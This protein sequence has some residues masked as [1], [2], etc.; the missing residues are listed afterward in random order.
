MEISNIR[1]LVKDFDACFDFY[2][3][4]LG[5]KASW[6]NLGEDYASFD[7]GIPSGLSLYKT[8]LM[9]TA[10]GNSHLPH[11]ENTREKIAVIFKVPD[12]DKVYN[13]LI[14]NEVSFINEPANMGGWGMRVVHL[15]DPENNLIEIWSEL[16]KN[17]WN[18]DLL[19]DAEKYE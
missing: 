9:A 19:A 11:T 2:K 7:V 16:A 18:N 17:K 4:K 12:V 1:L 13:K 8:D 3:N 14:K 5:L 6:G 15:R 10:I